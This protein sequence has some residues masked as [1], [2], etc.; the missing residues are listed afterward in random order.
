M[1]LPRKRALKF[2]IDHIEALDISDQEISELLAQVYVQ[3]GF[4]TADVAQT[5]F[6]PALVKQRGVLLTAQALLTKEFAGMVIVVPPTSNALVRAKENECE[7][8]LLGV[9]A[10]FRGHGLGRAL[11]DQALHFIQQNNWSNTVLWTQ[12]TMKEA[13]TLYESFGFIQTGTMTKSGIEF[14]VY[15]R[16]NT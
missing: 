11:I 16:Q 14:L 15:E 1:S 10:E 3:G 8:H 4:T 2:T 9:K 6:D 7:I 5:V 12:K 13:Q